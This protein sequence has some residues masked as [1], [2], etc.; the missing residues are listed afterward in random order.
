MKTLVFA[1]ALVAGILGMQAA[2]V[3]QQQKAPIYRYCLLEAGGFRSG[4]GS[5]LCRFNTLAQCLQSRNSFADTC[6]IN[7]EL[8][9]SR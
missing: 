7:P 5:T 6:I 4:G 2:A 3:A 8:T 9:R 1:G